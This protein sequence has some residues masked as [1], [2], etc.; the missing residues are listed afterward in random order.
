MSVKNVIMFLGE[1]IMN[2]KFKIDDYVKYTSNRYG[3]SVYNPLWGGKYGKIVGKVLKILCGGVGVKVEWNNKKTNYY[4]END[5]EFHCG[6]K[7]KE[8]CYKCKD[9]LKCITRGI[10]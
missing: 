10:I 4:F 1:K 2:S 3:D 8:N 5:I 6:K 9:R 7:S